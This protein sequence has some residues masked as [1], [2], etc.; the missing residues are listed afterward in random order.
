[1][2]GTCNELSLNTFISYFNYMEEIV[3]VI[4]FGGG[5]T[6]IG[7]GIKLAFDSWVEYSKKSDS[8]RK[9]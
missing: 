6:A 8:E 5:A 7:S 2:D 1:M 4:M 9:L 3:Y